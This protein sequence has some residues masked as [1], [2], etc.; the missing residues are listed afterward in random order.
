[1]TGAWRLA[2]VFVAVLMLAAIATDL[3]S[4][5]SGGTFVLWN[6]FGYFTIQN[7]LIGAAALLIAYT[8]LLLIAYKFHAGHAE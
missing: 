5:I 4:A 1:M 2:R 7:N 8:P 6:F 3:A